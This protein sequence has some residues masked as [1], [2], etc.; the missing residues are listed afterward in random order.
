MDLAEL[1]EALGKGQAPPGDVEAFVRAGGRALIFQQS[2]EWL[3]DTLG[4][5]VAWHPPRRVFPVSRAHPVTQGLEAED[6][7]DWTGISDLTEAYPKY[8]LCKPAWRSPDHGWHWGNRGAVSS[9]AVEKPHRSSWRPILE[10]EF[11]LAYTPLMELEYGKG[12]LILCAL[13]LESHA[14]QDPVARLLAKRVVEYAATAEILP[15]AERVIA[16]GASALLDELGVVC[17]KAE[18]L[19]T[20]HR[21]PQVSHLLGVILAQRQD[22]TGAADQM[23]N[24]LKFA[25]GAQ[26]AATVRGQLDQLEKLSA[27]SSPAQ[28]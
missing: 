7:R 26:D 8:P 2:P 17:A 22:Y 23:R 16:L 11:D 21:Y 15:K 12:R 3:R 20:E 4:F 10:C 25:P 19:D 9:A 27:Q 13:D 6:L 24:Y 1:G 14:D 28:Q 5:R 18:K